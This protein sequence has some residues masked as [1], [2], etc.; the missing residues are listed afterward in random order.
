MLLN[1]DF[2]VDFLRGPSKLH[3]LLRV[4]REV[5]PFLGRNKAY[6]PLLH[7][8]CSEEHL[9]G[10]PFVILADLFDNQGVCRDLVT[11]DFGDQESGGGG[12]SE[13][14]AQRGPEG[15]WHPSPRQERRYF[16]KDVRISRPGIEESPELLAVDLD[17]LSIPPHCA[18]SKKRSS[19]I[20]NEINSPL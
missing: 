12:L 10:S 20:G 4:K 8:Q 3:K 13:L 11:L 5:E 6:P 19:D 18:S 1:A 15:F 2:M 9:N 16:R 17:V 7:G 14:S